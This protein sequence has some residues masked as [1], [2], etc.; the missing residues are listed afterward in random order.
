MIARGLFH[1]VKFF[2]SIEKEMNKKRTKAAK[3]FCPFFF[4]L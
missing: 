3:H 2:I 4:I 1:K